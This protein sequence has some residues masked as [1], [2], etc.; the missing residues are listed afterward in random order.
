MRRILTGVPFY[1]HEL[2]TCLFSTVGE[3]LSHAQRDVALALGAGWDFWYTPGAIG[4]EE[5]YFPVPEGSLAEALCPG[6]RVT[7]VWRTTNDAE[8]AW[9]DIRELIIDGQVAIVAVDNFYL[10]F[11]PAYGDVHANH[12]VVVHGFDDER[13]LV[14][15][16]DA[17]PPAY[18]GPLALADL[19][20][21]RSSDH[22]EGGR[23][24]RYFAGSP[25]AHRELRLTFGRQPEM[26][27]DWL[28]GVMRANLTR[29]LAPANGGLRGISA[30]FTLADMA[31]AADPADPSQRRLF[32]DL[33]V[34]TAAARSQRALH[35]EF[36]RRAGARL[37]QPRL[38]RVARALD[39][40]ASGWVALRMLGS[41]E[42]AGH[43]AT[44]P[45]RVA[46][47]LR[48]IGTRERAAATELHDV[49]GR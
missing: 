4:R 3:A 17:M 23:P 2:A 42:L 6:Q 29:L 14:Y 39:R 28:V 11:R 22:R 40:A 45:R 13:R 36:L 37:G 24:D 47:R 33:V 32:E 19:Q 25:V 41:R 10:P 44:A 26:D 21:A 34:F 5:Y 35:G 31:E 15:V 43:P 49:L 46:E 9:H 1:R 27:A 30:I 16:V 20:R 38:R 12:L 8:R 18:R 7:S 48:C